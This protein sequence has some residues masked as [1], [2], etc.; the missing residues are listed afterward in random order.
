MYSLRHLLLGVLA[1]STVMTLVSLA[2]LRDARHVETVQ[3]SERLQSARVKLE[4]AL[5]SRLHMVR[6]LAAF[7]RTSES[8]TKE[9]FLRFATALEGGREGVRSLQLAPNAVVKFLTHPELNVGAEGHDLLGDPNRR[10]LVQ[11]VIDQ[12]QYLIAGPKTLVQGGV[13]VIGRLPVYLPAPNEP[14]GDRFW[15]F[16]TIVL[17]LGSL[18]VEAGVDANHP[19]LAFSLRGK[20]GLGSK[21]DVF[22]GDASAFHPNAITVDVAI[23]NGVWQLT[24]TVKPG[25]VLAEVSRAMLWGGG[26]VLS[27]LVGWWIFSLLHAPESLRVAADNAVAAWHESEQ[28]V[29]GIAANVPGAVYQRALSRHGQ[30]AYPYISPGFYELLEA[31]PEELQQWTAASNDLIEFRLGADEIRKWREAT[32]ASSV[33]GSRHDVELALL[34]PSG[35]ARR[36]RSLAITLPDQDGGFVWDGIIL[37]ITQQKLIEE[38]LRQSQR[39]E[40][41]GQ[42]AGGMAHD[43]NNLLAIVVGNLELLKDDLVGTEDAQ[44]VEQ[45]LEAAGRGAKLT[46]SMMAFARQQSLIEQVLSL[47][48]LVVSTMAISKAVLSDAVKLTSDL[49]SDLWPIRND[50]GQLGSALLNLVINARDAM[51][52]GGTLHVSTR[53]VAAKQQVELAVADTGTGMSSEVIERAFEPFFTT[54][55]VGRGSGLGLSMIY[56]LVQQSGGQVAITSPPDGGSTITLS[57]P[58]AVDESVADESSPGSSAGELQA[59]HGEVVLLVED[60]ADVREIVFRQLAKLGYQVLQAEDAIGALAMIDGGAKFDLLLTDVI[61]PRGMSGFELGRDV[62]KQTSVPIIYMSGNHATAGKPFHDDAVLLH[63]PVRHADLSAALRAALDLH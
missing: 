21:G 49:Q 8:F 59:A 52:D 39:M 23:P 43:F 50:A 6:G 4:A 19:D 40:S 46:R 2:I 25:S 60:D 11:R 22:Y 55:P 32:A 9:Q 30:I 63:K 14:A 33:G 18:L 53:N 36:I 34:L 13:G 31:T 51:P 5:H 7:V 20:D 12:R 28:R 1:A 47:N 10:E 62:R 26:L 44:F 24:A 57:F 3:M 38:Q 15:G 61:M 35:R 41:L 58:R 45:A 16:A 48:E 37:D 56:G 54:K 42:L 17:E 27:L 29:Q